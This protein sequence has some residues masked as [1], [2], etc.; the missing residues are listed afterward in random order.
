MGGQPPAIGYRRGGEEKDW[1]AVGLVVPTR[2][3]K[4]EDGL[5]AGEAGRGAGWWFVPVHVR[6][7]RVGSKKMRGRVMGWLVVLPLRERGSV[8][9]RGK[10]C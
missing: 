4:G 10:P 2:T 7:V 1:L 3:Q 6:G 9:K 5:V 8:H